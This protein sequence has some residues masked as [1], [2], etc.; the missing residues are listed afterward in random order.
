MNENMTPVVA[1]S[2]DKGML[3][4]GKERLKEFT[5]QLQIY[6][7]ARAKTEARI[8]SAEN[9]WKLRNSVEEEEV[10]GKPEGFVSSSAWLHNVITSKHA[11][12]VEAQPE[13]IV[14]PREEGDKD[15]AD[16][17]TSI[18]PVILAQNH[19]DSVYDAMQWSKLKYGTAVYKVVWDQSKLHGLGDIHITK[20]NLLDIYWEPGITDINRSRYLFHTELVDKDLLEEQYPHLAGVLKC[21][22]ITTAKFL[23]DDSVS[24]DKKC[25]VIDVYYRRIK[26]G[27]SVL[28]Y[29]KYVGDQVLFATENDPEYAETGLYEHGEFPYVFDTLYPIEGSPCGYGYVDIC[30]NPQCVIDLIKTA[31]VKNAM[32]GALPRFLSS[33]QATTINEK[34]FLDLKNSIIHVEG[35]L[36]DVQ[37]RPVDHRPLDSSC[38]ALVDSTIGEMRET[39]GNTETS[40]GTANSGV[41]AASAIAALQ[42]ASGKG[43]RDSI[44]TSY[45]AFAKVMNLVIELIRQFYDAPRHYRILG[46]G[47]V[48]KYISYTNRCLKPR[49]QGA[50]F[51]VDLGYY[52]P[53]FDVDVVAIK[54][55]AY[56]RVAQNELAMQLYDKGMLNPMMVDQAMICIGMMDFDG[57]DELMRKLASNA[58]M[59]QKLMTY[60]PIVMRY[61]QGVGDAMLLQMA[62]QDYAMYTGGQPQPATGG[63]GGALTDQG[64]GE[65]GTVTKA[66]EQARN[67][68][69]PT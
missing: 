41:T 56:T 61:A 58:T 27:N 63:A 15:E 49:P 62:S 52:K 20:C 57:K 68:S 21:N 5:R 7:G 37:F 40:T 26:G 66:R 43:S 53:C 33:N 14:L 18:L 65:H 1:D 67:A 19:F 35:S 31:M 4:V 50:A 32:V 60:L 22:T 2:E 45:R 51:G 44:A 30:K 12:A 29:C 34:E 54:K 39:S 17:L 69:Q 28:H 11:D 36:T 10:I 9:W 3:P 59:L 25:T 48:D 24:T 42:E 47:G 55:S 16:V 46:E 6:K 8:I 13:P 38:S 64:A 23:Y